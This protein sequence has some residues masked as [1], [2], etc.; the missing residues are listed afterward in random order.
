MFQYKILFVERRYVFLQLMDI[1]NIIPII[2]LL[3]HLV[4]QIES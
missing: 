3:N 4:S 1:A 2:C